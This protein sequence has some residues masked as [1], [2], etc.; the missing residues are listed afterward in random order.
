[1]FKNRYVIKSTWFQGNRFY[2]VELKYWWRP[3]SKFI[4]TS[5][6]YEVA[7]SICAELE[8]ESSQEGGQLP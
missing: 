7:K 1:M 6:N 8:S 5:M 3:F 4:T 2:D